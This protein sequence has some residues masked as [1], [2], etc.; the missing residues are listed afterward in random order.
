MGWFDGNQEFALFNMFKTGV[1]KPGLS[2]IDDIVRAAKGKPRCEFYRVCKGVRDSDLY[3]C[4]FIAARVEVER[5][6]E[7][8]ELTDTQWSSKKSKRNGIIVDYIMNHHSSPSYSC[9]ELDERLEAKGF[10]KLRERSA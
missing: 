6:G 5:F 2:S 9:E 8:G 4:Y 10:A 3:I 1:G 7:L